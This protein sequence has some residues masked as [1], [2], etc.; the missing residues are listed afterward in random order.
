MSLGLDQRVAA[1]LDNRACTGCGLCTVIDPGL[2]MTLDDTGFLRPERRPGTTAPAGAAETFARSCP[3]L[4][5]AAPKPAGA[6]RHR[7]LG[8]I[9]GVWAA[10]AT[11]P[12]L[13]SRGSSGGVLSAL[14]ALLAQDGRT[15]T[16]A[17]ADPT[18][19][20]RTVSVTITSRAEA[21]AA[22]GSR[23]AP[24]AAC[25]APGATDPAG[26]LVAKPCEV[27]AVRAWAAGTGREV[28]VLL[29]FFCAGTPSQ[30]AT[31]TLVDRLSPTGELPPADLWYRGR[32]WPGRFTVRWRDRSEA[33]LSYDQSWGEVLGR[34][35]QWRCKICP[36]GV[37]ESADVVAADLWAADDR[38]YPVFDEQ[39]GISALVARTTVGR[40]LVERAVAAGVIEVQAID[41]DRLAE[42]QPSQVRRRRTLLGRLAGAR[43]AGRGVPATRGFGFGRL[44]LA[45]LRDTVR[46]A[47]G[48]Y[49]RVRADADRR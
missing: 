35:V 25:A 23:Y 26:A 9:A 31:D 27:G 32:G 15:V 14:A 3:G 13:R 24:V 38:G 2:A 46:T 48:T 39:D 18:D 45:D 11:D 12:G 33:S 7:L 40:A 30:H 20:R 28:P 6:V 41:P 36:D 43:L 29:S 42:V 44:A 4:R 19:P 49:R 37:G 21:L 47:R 10:H 1:V 22:A 16:A 17:G 5:V 8:P 34:Q